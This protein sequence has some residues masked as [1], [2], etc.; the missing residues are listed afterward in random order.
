M[1]EFN[2]DYEDIKLDK[3]DYFRYH[4]PYPTKSDLIYR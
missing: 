1:N 4:K 3:Y 2:K